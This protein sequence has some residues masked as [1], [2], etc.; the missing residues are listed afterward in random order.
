MLGAH[1]GVSEAVNF[2]SGRAAI[3]SALPLFKK[4]LLL[5]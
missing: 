2:P 4:L 1:R 5:V 3:S